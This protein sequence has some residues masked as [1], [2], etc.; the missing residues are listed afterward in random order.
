[1]SHANGIVQVAYPLSAWPA[2]LPPDLE[3]TTRL[4]K[5]WVSFQTYLRLP[6]PN[7]LHRASGMWPYKFVTILASTNC[8]A[9]D[10]P[11]ERLHVQDFV[12]TLLVSFGTCWK[13]ADASHGK[14]ESF[15]LSMIEF[16]LVLWCAKIIL[17][18]TLIFFSLLQ[19]QISID[20]AFIFT[21]PRKY[22]DYH[23]KKLPD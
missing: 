1:M 10:L 17:Q 18:S 8:H 5:W 13:W 4:C 3:I 15:V 7:R 23:C 11:V 21:P 20:I 9:L 14:N 12:T 22:F 16:L 2:S 19:Y 6:G